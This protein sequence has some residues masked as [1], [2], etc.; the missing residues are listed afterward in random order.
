MDVVNASSIIWEKVPNAIILFY[1]DGCI[2]CKNFKVIY[3]EIL[4]EM[5]LKYPSIPVLQ[6]NVASQKV[7]AQISAGEFTQVPR[8]ILRKNGI[9]TLYTGQREKDKIIETFL[10]NIEIKKN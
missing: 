7:D 6:I 8:I 5:K 4:K 1:I 9:S 2:Y 10:H 3:K